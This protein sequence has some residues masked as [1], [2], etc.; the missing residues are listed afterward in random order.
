MIRIYRAN[1]VKF[2]GYSIGRTVI[3]FS[4]D[5]TVRPVEFTDRTIV[6]LLTE[7]GKTMYSLKQIQHLQYLL[8]NV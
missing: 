6:D 4:N 5:L 2:K 7:N 8:K 3:E 1:D